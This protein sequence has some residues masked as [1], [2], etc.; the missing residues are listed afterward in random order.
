MKITE[1]QFEIFKQECA[2][3]VDFFGLKNWQIHYLFK[4]IQNNRAEVT[5]DIVGGIATI[6]LNKSWVEMDPSLVNDR[7]IKK[8]AF[9]EICELFLC[10]LGYMVNQRY[11]LIYPDVEEEIHKIIRTLENVVWED[12]NNP[13]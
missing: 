2:K 4:Q 7:A 1:D 6:T 8:T 3:W 9:H 10:R 13:Y 12:Q 11:G 5:Y